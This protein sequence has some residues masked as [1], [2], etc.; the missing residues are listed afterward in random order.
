LNLYICH[1]TN[2][3]LVPV[4]GGVMSLRAAADSKHLFT[5]SATITGLP[6]GSYHFGLCG[7][8]TDGGS[9]NSN[10]YSYTTVLVTQ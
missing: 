1:E 7:F 8:S 5:L 2:G 6:A 4:G 10:E 9:W 3:N